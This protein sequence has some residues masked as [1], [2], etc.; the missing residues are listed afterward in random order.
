MGFV[1]PTLVQ[2]KAVPLALSGRDLLVRAATG[3]GKTAAYGL[4]V[5]QKVIQAKSSGGRGASVLALILVPTRELVDQTVAVLSGLAHYCGDLLSVVGLGGGSVAEQAGRLA[6]EPSIVV[7]TPARAAAHVKACSLSL[8]A[9]ST[10][11]LDEAD[12]MLS[13]GHAGDVRVLTSALPRGCQGLLLSATLSSALVELKSLVLHSPAVLTLEEGAGGGAGG[14]TQLFVRTPRADRYLLLYALLR[15]KLVAGKTLVFVGNVNAGYRLKLVLDKFGIPSA[16]LNAE[17]PFNSRASVVSQFNK[18]LFDILIATDEG[19]PQGEGEGGGAPAAE[20]ASGEGEEEGEGSAPA[21]T[22]GKGKKRRRAEAPAAGGSK[23]AAASAVP[24]AE[25]GV[26]RGLDFTG[27][28][29]VVNFDFP[30]S[31][32]SYVHRVGRTA[33]AGAA[34]VALSLMAPVGVEAGSDTVLAALQAGQPPDPAT[35]SPLPCPLPFDVAEVEPFR[36][37]V[38][39][40]VRSVTDRAIKDAR[41]EE[42]RREVLASAALRGHFEDNPR[43]LAVLQHDAPLAG[44]GGKRGVRARAGPKG[45]LKHVPDYLLPPSLRSALVAAGSSVDAVL[46]G[47]KRKKKK[48]KS[49]REVARAAS[50]AAM[51]AASAAAVAASLAAGGEMAPIPGMD[52]G[53]GEGVKMSLVE[54][55][56][57]D[58]Y[59]RHG[60]MGRASRADPLKTFKIASDRSVAMGIILPGSTGGKGGPDAGASAAVAVVASSALPARIERVQLKA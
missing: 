13:Y 34:G 45:H 22:G 9:L 42:L 40:Q 27:I 39:D 15:L 57:A 10:I 3:S 52:S 54:R 56:Q 51:S 33:R 59:S 37:R 29:T 23:R 25:Y 49:A 11:V 5:L 36:Y 16:V 38:E 7:S 4:A 19:L 43:D 50:Q 32:T 48:A 6:S 28:R 31:V 1:R 55:A 20:G 58:A 17:L 35:G 30:P 44:A 47:G 46:A 2:A 26:S 12:L 53:E 60:G 41:L 8:A 18:G 21:E 24:D 14:L